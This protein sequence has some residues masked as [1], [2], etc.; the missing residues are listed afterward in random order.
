MPDG[1]RTSYAYV[2]CM[3]SA[4]DNVITAAA[5]PDVFILPD[6]TTLVLRAVEPGDRDR[7]QDLFGRLSPLSRYRRFLSAKPDLGASELAALSDVD[8]LRH[9][10]LAAA[11]QRDGSFA[12]VARYVQ[13]PERPEAAEMA[14][15]V[16]DELHG[17]GVG[18]CLTA[19]ILERARDNG[20]ALLTATTLRENLPARALLRRFGF[21][22]TASS[23]PLIELERE[24]LVEMPVA[25]AA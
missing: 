10:A 1:K 8:H 12:G 11:D 6:G 24:L 19:R 7:L 18:S 3:H 17:F 9:E 22:P 21:S 5:F 14:I 2:D 13:C 20:F 16:D 15:E 23:G 25:S 4:P